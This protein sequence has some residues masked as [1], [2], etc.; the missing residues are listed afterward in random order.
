MVYSATKALT[1]III[2]I[3][4]ERGLL[5]LEAPVAQYW[6]AFGQNDKKD[7]TIAHILLH[8]AGIPGKATLSEVASWFFPGIPE[9]RVA[10]MRPLHR[11]GEKAI[12]HPFTGGFV[13]GELI[14]RVSGISPATFARKEIF[15]PLG[16]QNSWPGLPLSLQ[17]KASRIYSNDPEQNS[18]ARRFAWYCS[19]HFEPTARKSDMYTI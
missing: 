4:A 3:L 8:Q 10:S 16:M 6:P 7:I 2:H 18:A 5:D 11:P 13:L 17:S 14:R 19:Y 15:E 12:Y 9:R 1:A